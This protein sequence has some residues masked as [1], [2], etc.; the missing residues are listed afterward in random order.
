MTNSKYNRGW[1]NLRSLNDV[2]PEEKHAIQSAGGKASAVAKKERRRLEELANRILTLQLPCDEDIRAELE[3]HGI[4][5]TCDAGIVLAQVKR[6]LDGDV[7]AAIWIR[8]ILGENPGNRITVD[9]P[10][11]LSAPVATMDLSQ[12]SDDELRAMIAARE[13]VEEEDC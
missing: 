1:D 12:L 4:D 6:A 2:S 8:N 7:K 10:D 9:M 13:T 5:P 3:A 11:Y